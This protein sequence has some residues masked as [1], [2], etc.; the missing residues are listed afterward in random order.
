MA[1]TL[2]PDITLTDVED[3]LVLL[4]QRAGR[5]W[6]LNG[7]GATALR[8]LLAGRS[9][10]E[11]ARQLGERTPD[12]AGR[13]LADVRSLITALRRARLLVPR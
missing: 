3:G 6:H 9:P 8:L 1:I 12:A 11:T 5:Y 4:D 7:T 2:T 13:A 10:E